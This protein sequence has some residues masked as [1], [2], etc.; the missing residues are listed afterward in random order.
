MIILA[1]SV[2]LAGCGTQNIDRGV[3]GAGIGAAIGTGVGAI[4]GLSLLEG[5]VIG[6]AVGGITALA[7]RPNQVNFGEPV[8]RQYGLHHRSP[9]K[10]KTGPSYSS[11]SGYSSPSSGYSTPSTT[12][13]SST[14]PST[15]STNYSSPPSYSTPSAPATAYPADQLRGQTDDPETVRDV[16]LGLTRLGYDPGPANGVMGPKTTAAIKSFQQQHGMANTGQPNSNL[17]LSLHQR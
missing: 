15:P 12:T 14:T 4:T 1:A 9:S 7:T 2:S 8:W 17:A 10:T 16:Q 11:P 6:T 3:S 5:A 13:P